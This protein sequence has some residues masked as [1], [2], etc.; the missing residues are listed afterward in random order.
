MIIRARDRFSVDAGAR[1]GQSRSV[2]TTRV[3]HVDGAKAR[4]G[5]PGGLVWVSCCGPKPM[6]MSG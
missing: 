2:S 6:A 1:R 3:V 5:I 4:H